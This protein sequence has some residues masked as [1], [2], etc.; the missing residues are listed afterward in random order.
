MLFCADLHEPRGSRLIPLKF[1]FNAVN[2]I[3]RCSDLSL[4]VVISTQFALEMCLVA[5]NR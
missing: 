5:Q 3:H 4:G 1:A 2:F